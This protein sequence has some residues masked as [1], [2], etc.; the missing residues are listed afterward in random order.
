L[1]I[2]LAVFNGRVKANGFERFFLPA[3]YNVST[4]SASLEMIKGAKALRQQKRR[5]K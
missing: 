2:P 1:R 3:R 5:L 4:K